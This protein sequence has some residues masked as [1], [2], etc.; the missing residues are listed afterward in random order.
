MTRINSSSLSHIAA[1]IKLPPWSKHFRLQ[2]WFPLSILIDSNCNRV[3]F[4]HKNAN[5]REVKD[6]GKNGVT[7]REIE[8]E[9]DVAGVAIRCEMHSRSEGNYGKSMGVLPVRVGIGFR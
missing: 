4:S 1:T 8:K 7:E 9:E 2:C 3:L 5:R 6:A